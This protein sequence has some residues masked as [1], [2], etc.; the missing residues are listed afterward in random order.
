MRILVALFILSFC[1]VGSAQLP[2]VNDVKPYYP[3]EIFGWK[4]VDGP[5]MYDLK[6]IYDYMDGAADK[7]RRYEL[8]QLF[9]AKYTKGEAKIV[10]EMFDMTRP[11]EAFGVNSTHLEGNA[12][13]I[14]R[15]AKYD[16][17]AVRFWRGRYFMKVYD[18]AGGDAN[19]DDVI[20]I[21]RNISL[22]MPDD[23]APP[24]LAQR[25]RKW[26]LAAVDVHYF[27]TSEDL[28]DFYYIATEN[29]LQLGPKAEGVMADCTIAKKSF[30]LA[31]IQYPDKATRAKAIA[32]CKAK[33]FSK[34][35]KTDKAGVLTEAIEKGKLWGMKA[36]DGRNK[37]IWLALVLAAPSPAL[38]D[39]AIGKIGTDKE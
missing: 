34:K 15:D 37:E 33:V 25:I 11:E 24:V 26:G 5:T 22:L 13:P 39:Q 21:A 36:I 20:T 1:V 18:D 28:N 12:P 10:I 14:D 4:L 6:T 30:K 31:L 38:C 27:H 8:A 17:G 3:A 19:R 23:G 2:T 7:Y 35:A 16:F 29:V 32:E 9:V